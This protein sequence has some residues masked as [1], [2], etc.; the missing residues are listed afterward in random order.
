MSR[1]A[2]KAVSSRPHYW[3]PAKKFGFG[4]GVPYA[5]QGWVVL[6]AYVAGTV[7]A[8]VFFPPGRDPLAFGGIV[9]LLSLLLVLVCSWKGEPIL[10]DKRRRT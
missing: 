9:A 10:S 6:L 8:G 5:W 2:H 3:L 1:E 7:L 4:W